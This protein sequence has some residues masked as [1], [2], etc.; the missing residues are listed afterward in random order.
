VPLNIAFAFFDKK[1][2]SAKQEKNTSRGA[3]AA[4]GERQ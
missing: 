4:A 3:S 1:I 2:C